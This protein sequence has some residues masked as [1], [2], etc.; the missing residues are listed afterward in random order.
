VL[1]AKER[2]VGRGNGE[3]GRIENGRFYL[4]PDGKMERGRRRG[5][6]EVGIGGERGKGP[7]GS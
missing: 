6:G 2:E 7:R 5:K 4:V 3:V 1:L